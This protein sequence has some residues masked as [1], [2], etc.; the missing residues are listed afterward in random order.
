[1]LRRVYSV[2]FLLGSAVC[3][4]GA[5]HARAADP[6]APDFSR[7]P[8]IVEAAI[9][10]HA[11]PGCSVAIGNHRQVLFA[12]GFGHLDYEGGPTVTTDTL[13]D[14]ASVTKIIGATSV[15][16]TLVHDGKLSIGD[17][18]SKFVPEFV[19][20]GKDDAEKEQR[21]KVTIAH[22]MTH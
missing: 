5:S 21:A 11:F 3:V 17:P 13:Y 22:L 2:V 7:I 10:D 16:I 12:R 6:P 9:K 4:S 19:A 18:V 8:E 20:A 14:L 15:V 1:M